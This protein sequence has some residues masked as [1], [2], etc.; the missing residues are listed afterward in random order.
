M[1]RTI[2]SI[3][4]ALFVTVLALLYPIVLAKIELMLPRSSSFF[5]SPLWEW[6]IAYAVLLAVGAWLAFAAL[7]QWRDAYHWVLRDRFPEDV[8]F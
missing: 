8:P 3:V 2:W 6:W 7:S 5:A 4:S 1:I